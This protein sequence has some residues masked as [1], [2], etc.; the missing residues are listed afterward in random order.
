MWD[1]VWTASAD[2]DLTTIDWDGVEPIHSVLEIARMDENDAPERNSFLTVMN[3]NDFRYEGLGQDRRGTNGQLRHKHPWA[4]D[5]EGDRAMTAYLQLTDLQ[6]KSAF[7]TTTTWTAWLLKAPQFWA[8]GF[9]K[10]PF[11]GATKIEPEQEEQEGY[12]DTTFWAFTNTDYPYTPPEILGG[13][14]EID[15]PMRIELTFRVESPE[16][17]LTEY[18]T[19]K[20]KGDAE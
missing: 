14:Q 3:P 13:K 17:H 1:G 7:S 11:V 6:I 18:Y 19:K 2:E 4:R 20:F 8:P 10:N 16:G 12:G 15:L 9:P 5:V